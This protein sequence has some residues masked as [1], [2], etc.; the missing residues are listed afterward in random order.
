MSRTRWMSKS[1]KQVAVQ[2]LEAA[3]RSLPPYS[4]VRSP[5]KFTQHQLFAIAVLR[6]F[7]RAD[8]RGIAAILEDS[9]DLRAVLGLKGVPHYSTLAYA[10]QRFSQGGI[11]FPAAGY[12]ADGVLAGPVA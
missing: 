4:A 12:G 10:E 11:R 5:K 7:F 2:A 8:Y 9:S 3:Q 6:Q 1:P